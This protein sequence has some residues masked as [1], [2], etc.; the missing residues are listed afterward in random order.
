MCTAF[1]G[2]Y[3]TLKRSLGDVFRA[4]ARILHSLGRARLCG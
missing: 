4:D 3:L 2:G 1:V